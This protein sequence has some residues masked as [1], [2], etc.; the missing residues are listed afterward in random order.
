MISIIVPTYNEEKTILQILKSIEEAFRDVKYEI[1][2]IDDGSIDDTQNICQTICTASKNIKYMKLPENHGKGFALRTG[3]RET[4]GDFVAIQDADLEYNPT[5]LRE[6]Y[7]HSKE[8]IVIYGKRDKNKGYFWTIIGS[9]FLSWLCNL[10]YNSR[11]YDIYT[12]YKIIPAKILRSLKLSA[13]GFEIEAEITAKLLNLKIP[14]IEIPITYSPRTFKE[15]KHIRARDAMIG[16]WTL[17]KNRFQK[18]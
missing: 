6:L 3:F 15:G 7:N 16:I 10:L 12:C 14:I 5:I 4:T 8:N 9:M 13:N 2:V 11:L 1:I 17:I 18:S